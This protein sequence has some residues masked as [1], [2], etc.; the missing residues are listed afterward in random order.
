L[1][2]SLRIYLIGFI[3]S[4]AIASPAT[5]NPVQSRIFSA[6][7]KQVNLEERARYRELFKEAFKKIE[8]HQ[9]KEAITDFDQAVSLR[10]NTSGAN[11][12]QVTLA[13]L[14]GAS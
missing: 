1:K 13:M 2:T 4:L 5:A 14:N 12:I 3:A 10:F 7:K 9:Y 6:F 8:T 11:P